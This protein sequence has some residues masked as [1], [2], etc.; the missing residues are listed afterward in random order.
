MTVGQLKKLLA[1]LPDN[2]PVLVPAPDHSYRDRVSAGAI[3]ALYAVEGWSEDHGE[4]VTP[5][6]EYGK[7]YTVFVVL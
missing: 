2:T 6:A 7:R 3:T 1:E 4:D 5:E